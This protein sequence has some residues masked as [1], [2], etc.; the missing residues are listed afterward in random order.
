MNNNLLN[1]VK[2]IVAKN[3]ETV[4]SDPKLVSAFLKDLAKDE[5]KPQKYALVKCLEQGFAQMLKNVSESERHNCKQKLAHRLKDEEGLDLDLCSETVELLAAV[6]FAKEEAAKKAAE[7]AARKAAEE[8][9]KQ[10]AEALAREKAEREEREAKEAAERA[11]LAE[12]KAR[13][14]KEAAE[15]K[16]REE[17]EAAEKLRKAAEQ[18]NVEAQYILGNSYF[19]GQGEI[20]NY[21]KAA[22]WFNK[23]AEQEHK[24]A[25]FI[26]GRWYFTGHGITQ[27]YAKA[28]EWLEKAAEQGHGEAKDWLAKAEAADKAERLHKAAEQGDAEAQFNLGNSYF[29]GQGETKDYAK[30]AEWFRK[31]A[32]QGHREAQFSL[33]NSYLT[34]Q[35]ETQNYEKAA[36]WLRKATEQGHRE[37]QFNLG[38]LYFTGQGENRDYAKAAEW[39][40]KAAEQGHG[41]AKDWLAKA[42]AAVDAE[43]A[44]K[45]REAKEAAE[46]KAIEKRKKAA[47]TIGHVF[48]SLFVI[49]IVAA[50]IVFISRMISKTTGNFFDFQQNDQGTLTI[51]GYSGSKKVVI[52]AANEG[53]NVTEIGDNAFYR[54]KLTS[55]VIPDGITT[56]GENAFASNRLTDVVIPDSVTTIKK[57]AFSDNRLTDVVIPDSVTTIGEDVFSGNH[58]NTPDSA[59]AE[60]PLTLGTWKLNA[61]ERGASVWTWHGGMWSATLHID[62]FEN[63]TFTG[64]FYWRNKANKTSWGYENFEGTY[65]ELTRQVVIKG[66]SLR[67]SKGPAW[68]WRLGEYRATLSANGKGLI[69]G[70]WRDGG[71]WEAKLYRKKS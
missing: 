65:N 62:T 17:K 18:G 53:I 66:T 45:E 30:A 29:T 61:S 33:G 46:R 19:T 7:E 69:N 42:E 5:P 63:N 21:T 56:I 40:G 64:Y 26:L 35:G 71:T 36:E 55:V 9:A 22:E 12:K 11:A 2:E 54:K 14:A 23:A 8:A 15:K 39:F 48:V 37:A 32:E 68:I 38:N 51:T 67:T 16:A 31:A 58:K 60:P 50:L 24:E 1:V 4:L 44:Q 49:A 59:P 3:G 52:P 6:I 13:E 70:T 10:R 25:Q 47:K 27:D 20:Q 41:E 28:V 43:K 34:G 57:N